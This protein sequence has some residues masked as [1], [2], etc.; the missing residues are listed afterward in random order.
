[1][2]GGVLVGGVG[3]VYRGGCD[4][5]RVLRGTAVALW[6]LQITLLAAP[7]LAYGYMSPPF[8][9]QRHFVVPTAIVIVLL[10]AVI[11]ARR[12]AIVAGVWLS[13]GAGAIVHDFAPEPCPY[14]PDLT[15]LQQCVDRGELVCRQ[16]IFG[17]GWSIELR[18]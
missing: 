3:L 6:L 18:R 14:R 5:D 10:V 11:G 12:W 17:S 1:M 13:V 15:G 9:W 16:A 4:H 2:V 7:V 8:T